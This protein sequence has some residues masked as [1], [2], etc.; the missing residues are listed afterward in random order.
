VKLGKGVP[1]VAWLAMGLQESQ[2][3]PGWYNRYTIN[4][5]KSVHFNAEAAS[6]QAL[7]NIDKRLTYF[8]KNPSAALDFFAKKALSEWNEPSYESLW[9]SQVKGH[10]KPVPDFVENVYNG[11]AGKGLQNYFNMYQQIILIGFLFALINSFRKSNDLFAFLPLII[12]GGFLYHLLF[13]AKSQY[14]LVYF[15]M[16]VPYAAYGWNALAHLKVFDI[17]SE[18][19]KG[20]VE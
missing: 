7:Q 11:E 8:K 1:Q 17:R 18:N 20:K 3:A 4:T 12:L 15:V 16:L 5:F 13:E 9:V 6:A 2:M 19:N 10:M 14:I